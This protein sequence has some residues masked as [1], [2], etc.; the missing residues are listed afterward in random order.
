MV[1]TARMVKRMPKF[2]GASRPDCRCS[3]LGWSNG[4]KDFPHRQGAGL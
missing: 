3:R 4:N 2:P 1:G